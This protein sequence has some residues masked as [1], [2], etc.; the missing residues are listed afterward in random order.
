MIRP[1]SQPLFGS[2]TSFNGKQAASNP[3]A[4]RLEKAL[5]AIYPLDTMAFN[6][7]EAPQGET[8]RYTIDIY[9][10]PSAKAEQP[11]LEASPTA[12]QIGSMA[13]DDYGAHRL[14]QVAE[15]DTAELAD[16]LQAGLRD[17]RASKG[18]PGNKTEIE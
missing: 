15:E 7:K 1:G 6:V 14:S 2:A 13:L 10:T 9:D 8:P 17:S 18:N 11:D 4:R 5:G 3:V 12:R 16:T